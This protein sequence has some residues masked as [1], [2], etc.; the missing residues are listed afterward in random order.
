[1]KKRK[2]LI[3]LAS[4]FCLILVPWSGIAS[5]GGEKLIFATDSWAPYYGPDLKNNGFI[6]EITRAA[7][8]KAGYEIEIKFMDWN[9]AMQMAKKGKY[10]G[11]VG[12]YFSEERA[13]FFK[14]PDSI[15]NVE[16]VLCGRKGDNIK[17]TS[18]EDLKPYK[19]G[20]LRGYVNS[21]EFDAASFLKK[22]PVE[23][24]EI[25]IKKLLKGRVDLIVDSKAVLQDRI[26][27]NFKNAVG[28]F[29]F[30]T[31]ALQTNK[32]YTILSKTVPGY[33]KKA[34]DFNKGLKMILE[35]GT[36]IEI[37]KRHG[38]E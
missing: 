36:V 8:K 1:M 15:G 3:I 34:E 4:F 10:D 18:L 29:E 17:F 30:L 2:A 9:R 26:N 33:E 13:N 23:K 25:N 14:Y 32:L 12:A 22:E 35:D 21:K 20:V 11:I 31:P 38:F 24:T 16:V 37:L 5:A 27:R 19:I 28:K 6:A 7:F